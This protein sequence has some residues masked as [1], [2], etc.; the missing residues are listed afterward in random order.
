MTPTKF[1]KTAA[2]SPSEDTRSKDILH[3][4][5]E[6][7]S[8]TMVLFHGVFD[9][10]R[11]IYPDLNTAWI[12]DPSGKA[13]EDKSYNFLSEKH[14]YDTCISHMALNENRTFMKVEQEDSVT[15]L[16]LAAPIMIDGRKLVVELSKEIN[17][18]FFDYTRNEKTT[19][20][21]ITFGQE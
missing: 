13:F 2:Q 18:N 5:L 4:L 21:L 19:D 16:V 8:H 6:Q 14:S 3:A 20:T 9:K 10:G 7:L 11:I 15:F 17:D 1:S 12:I